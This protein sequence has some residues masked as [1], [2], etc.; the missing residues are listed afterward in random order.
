V[1]CSQRLHAP[2]ISISQNHCF[3]YTYEAARRHPLPRAAFYWKLCK[4][5]HTGFPH[6]CQDPL[7]KNILKGGAWISTKPVVEKE[8]ITPEMIHSI[9]SKYASPSANLSSLQIAALL[10]VHF[11]VLM[12]WVS[13]SVVMWISIIWKTLRLLSPAVRL[14]RTGMVFS[15]YLY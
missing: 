14:T 6:P 5:L 8:P 15:L 2:L 3:T 13:R 7:V 10:F 12:T 4:C 11:Y 1:H 9:C